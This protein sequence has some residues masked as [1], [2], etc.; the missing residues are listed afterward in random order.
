VAVIFALL[1]AF[2]LPPRRGDQVR[3]TSLTLAREGKCRVANLG[4][5]MVGLDPHVDVNAFAS[6]RLRPAD[7]A[8]F[9][10]NLAYQAGDFYRV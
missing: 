2:L 6:G 3:T 10:E 1:A 4:E 9:V 8:D 5:S 7:S